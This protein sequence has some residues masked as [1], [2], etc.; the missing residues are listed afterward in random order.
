MIR[1]SG[2]DL[3]TRMPRALCRVLVCPPPA[4]LDLD[5]T[6]SVCLHVYPSRAS[7]FNIA[8]V[9]KQMIAARNSAAVMVMDR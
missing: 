7:A 4:E 5:G 1:P 6:K 9:A 2:G 3:R 8:L